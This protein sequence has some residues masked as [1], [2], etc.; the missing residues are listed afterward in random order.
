MS[1]PATK[2]TATKKSATH[3]KKAPA[4]VIV[5]PLIAPSVCDCEAWITRVSQPLPSHRDFRMEQLERRVSHI[6]E[7]ESRENYNEDS[8]REIDV[9]GMEHLKGYESYIHV[10]KSK[11]EYVNRLAHLQNEFQEKMESATN[12]YFSAG[13]YI[14]AGIA[15]FMVVA[16]L[17]PK[18]GQVVKQR[19]IY[20]SAYLD[21]LSKIP[22]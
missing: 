17:L 8:Y 4:K 2:K 3:K 9:A 14:G 20:K 21:A 22:S 6:L 5:E 13:L 16:I 12:D 7:A 1:T 18:F 11:R 19:E 15:M 10:P